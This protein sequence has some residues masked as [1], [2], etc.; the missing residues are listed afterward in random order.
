MRPHRRLDPHIGLAFALALTIVGPLRAQMTFTPTAAPAL[1]PFPDAQVRRLGAVHLAALVGAYRRA[2][3]GQL[4][5]DRRADGVVMVGDQPILLYGPGLYHGLINLPLPANDAVFVPADSPAGNGAIALVSERGLELWRHDPVTASLSVQ[6]VA[7]SKWAG[8]RRVTCADLDGNGTPELLGIG[9]SGHEVLVT[10]ALPLAAFAMPAPVI[11][12]EPIDWDGDGKCELAVLT[13]VAAS[14]RSLDGGLVKAFA[15]PLPTT[16]I[17]VFRDASLPV[18]RQ[19]LAL[20]NSATGILRVADRFSLSPPLGADVTG[21]T[22]A[23]VA[24][25]NLDGRDDLAFGRITGDVLLLRNRGITATF[26]TTPDASLVLDPSPESA[27]T[28]SVAVPAAADLD[29]DGDADLLMPDE[30]THTIAMLRNQHIDHAQHTPRIDAA[31]YTYTAATQTGVLTAQ[32]SPPPGAG[33]TPIEVVVWRQ[34]D[35]DA[36]VASTALMHILLKPT[37][38]GSLPPLQLT[39]GEDLLAPAL[40]SIELRSFGMSSTGTGGATSPTAVYTLG[41]QQSALLTIAT[42]HQVDAAAILPVPLLGDVVIGSDV[43]V[44]L[45]PLGCVPCFTDDE[46][47]DPFPPN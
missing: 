29:G 35:A 32:I 17:A 45:V 23:A 37:A 2:I 16:G 1:G 44:G 7:G 11:D 19:R 22:D 41:T 25:F 5:D 28:D 40:Y 13:E 20:F 36:P 33:S 30:A 26:A 12:L 38:T 14:I 18:P 34:H 42:L 4:T 46:F 47:P 24:D 39:I 21:V 31:T 9:A 43:G 6:P 8:A 27:A 15:G 3:V 10:A